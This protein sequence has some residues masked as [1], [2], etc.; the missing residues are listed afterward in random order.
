[1]NVGNAKAHIVH[2]IHILKQDHK[3]PVTLHIPHEALKGLRAPPLDFSACSTSSCL[4]LV[5]FW[6]DISLQLVPTM[7]RFTPGT[8]HLL[9]TC[10][11]QSA[12]AAPISKMS[13][14]TQGASGALQ[15]DSRS[16]P[17][18]RQLSTIVAN[19][20]QAG[21]ASTEE[22]WIHFLFS[23]ENSQEKT[24]SS[25][26]LDPSSSNSW[27]SAATTQAGPSDPEHMDPHVNVA[28]PQA[29]LFGAIFWHNLK[30]SLDM[31]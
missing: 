25:L 23:G 13:K 21:S 8:L 7:R 19:F 26:K 18:T 27:F 20:A 30:F 4:A 5:A 2:C 14:K 9:G 28:A 29:G 31:L 1:M 11:Q 17:G 15:R 16:K 22:A 3:R 24:C 6:R 10:S 12:L